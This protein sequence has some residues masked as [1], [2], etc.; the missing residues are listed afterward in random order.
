MLI[1]KIVFIFTLVRSSMKK[2]KVWCYC[3]LFVCSRGYH[4]ESAYTQLQKM[5]HLKGVTVAFRLE[6]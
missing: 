5:S 2:E 1:S 6:L 3:V 4:F